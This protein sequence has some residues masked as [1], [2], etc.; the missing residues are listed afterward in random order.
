LKVAHLPDIGKLLSPKSVALIGASSDTHGL[1]GRILEIMKGHPFGGTLYPVSRSEAEVQGLKAYR[2]IAEVP[3]PV[4]LA[5]VIIPAKHVPEELDRCGRAGVK[6]AV[7]LSSGF[8]EEPGTGGSGLQ[9]EIRTVARRYDMAVS[10]PNAEGFAN[11]PAALCPTFSPAMEAGARPLLPPPERRRGTVAVI[12]QS[13]GMGFAFF[14]RGRPKDLPFRYIV[15][16]GNEACLETFDYV[17]HML[18]EGG[19]DV[20]LLLIEDVKTPETFRR[21]AEKALRAGKPLIVSKIGQSDAGS[22]AAAS[23]TAA[24]A[25]SHAV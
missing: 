10:G 12:A 24:L 25:G 18:D 11:L 16:T 4:D 8:A 23:H 19:T 17:D 20:F 3:G 22:R 2:S 5:V 7:V 1:R 21:V 6:A 9:D 13:G 14:D 15:S